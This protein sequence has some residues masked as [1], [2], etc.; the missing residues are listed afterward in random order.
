[1]HEVAEGLIRLL[2]PV[3]VFTAEEAWTFLGRTDSVHTQLFPAI[4]EKIDNAFSAR[5]RNLLQLRAAVN[6]KL[7]AARRDKVI[8]KSLEAAVELALPPGENFSVADLE[9]LFIVSKVKLKAE[10]EIRV[11]RAEDEGAKKCVR[12]WRFY[13]ELGSDAGHPELCERCTG[14]VKGL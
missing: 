1:M 8:G 7:E 2:A 3:L 14:V 12:C 4:D 13:D 9:E 11:S 6:E 10:G 5:W